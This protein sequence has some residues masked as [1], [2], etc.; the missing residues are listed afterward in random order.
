MLRM[1]KK[2]IK[3][4]DNLYYFLSYYIIENIREKLFL[5]NSFFRNKA[6]FCSKTYKNLKKFKDIHKGERCFIIATGPSLDI[7]E[8][9]KLHNEVTFS[10]NSIVLLFDKIKWR[11]CYY[12]IQDLRA[13]SKLKNQILNSKL[14]VIFNGIVY[15]KKS[16]ELN[17]RS[18]FYPLNLLRHNA[19]FKKG[20]TRF[21]TSFSD[22]IYISVYDGYSI[23]YSLLQIAA[24]M[25]FKEI[26]LLGVDC[27]YSPNNVENHPLYYVKQDDKNAAYL[28]RESFKV[29]K[30]YAEKKDIKIYNASP[31]SKLDIFE[32]IELD[33]VLKMPKKKV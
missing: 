15:R 5:L 28:M 11:P 8:L 21:N 6:W 18:Y 31:R 4:Y 22:D 10:M 7:S 9:E 32:K 2:W 23:T 3:K 19:P 16:R 30:V 14:P 33:A 27:D 20:V 13:Y 25:G 29:A 24:Y 1:L 26:Y 12:G 17:L